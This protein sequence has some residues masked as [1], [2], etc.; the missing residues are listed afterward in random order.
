M[1]YLNIYRVFDMIF[2]NGRGIQK[3]FAQIVT[4]T[5]NLKI[6]GKK[7]HS[8]RLIGN[9]CYKLKLMTMFFK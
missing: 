3:F 9:S 8:I 1:E 2:D 5:M 6:I 4:L 7:A